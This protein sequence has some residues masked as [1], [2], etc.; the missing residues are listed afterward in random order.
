M[1]H[2]WFRSPTIA[3]DQVSRNKLGVAGNT[4]G[5]SGDL[6]TL[7]LSIVEETI[8]VPPAPKALGIAFPPRSP[9]NISPFMPSQTWY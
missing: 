7:H 9:L 5:W 2:L 1:R 6:D 4:E 8:V 3:L